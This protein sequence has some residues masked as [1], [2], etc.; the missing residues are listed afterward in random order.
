MVTAYLCNLHCEQWTLLGTLCRCCRVL[1]FLVATMRRDKI[2][3]SQSISAQSNCAEQRRDY[4]QCTWW[5]PWGGIRYKP[6]QSRSCLN[7]NSGWLKVIHRW[8]YEE[9][10]RK[11]TQEFTKCWVRTRTTQ[12]RIWPTMCCCVMLQ[13]SRAWAQWCHPGAKSWHLVQKI[14]QTN[15]TRRIGWRQKN[16]LQRQTNTKRKMLQT[17][18]EHGMDAHEHRNVREQ[19]TKQKTQNTKCCRPRWHMGWVRSH[20][21]IWMLK[22]KHKIQSRKHKT[23]NTQDGTWDGC[24]RAQER[25]VGFRAEGKS[26]YCI[27]WI[28]QSRIVR[29]VTFF[30]TVLGGHL[31]TPGTL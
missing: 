13:V 11:Q 24:T 28:V 2:Q 25:R 17:K 21:S 29:N 3:D 14:M 19:N 8:F 26:W 5:W 10:M 6:S 1:L 27:V 18:M 7:T 22:T 31:K 12:P 15:M 16:K 9:E 20:T 23:Q 4:A 30:C